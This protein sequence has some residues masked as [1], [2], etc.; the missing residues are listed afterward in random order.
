MCVDVDEPWD[1]V[2]SWRS[3]G[4]CCDCDWIGLGRTEVIAPVEETDLGH[5][6]GLHAVDMLLDD[7]VPDWSMSEESFWPRWGAE[8][9]YEWRDRALELASL[10]PFEERQTY[11]TCAN[12]LEARRWLEVWCNSFMF[13]HYLD[14]VFEHWDQDEITH[15]L[16]TGRLAVAARDRWK[17]RGRRLAP[18]EAKRLVDDSL[19][20]LR[21]LVA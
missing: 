4:K 2:E 21:E 1:V 5:G 17:V 7:G 9:D 18:D 15:S 10:L 8:A 19:A 13:A 16:R 3:F 11:H 20:A 14:D 6:R 12:C